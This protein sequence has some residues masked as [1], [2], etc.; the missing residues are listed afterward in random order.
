V[1]A[2]CYRPLDSINMKKIRIG[3]MGCASIAK[4]SVIPAIIKLDQYFEL[5]AIASRT[6]D[7]ANKFAAEFD[8]EGIEGYDNLISRPDIDAIYVPLPTGLH[9]EWILKT[10]NAGKHIYAEKSIALNS[11]DANQMIDLARVHDLALM[12]GYMFQYHSQHKKVFEMIHDGSL[13]EIRHFSASFGFPPLKSENFR[14]NNEI[15]GGALMDCA[16]YVVRSAFFILQQELR[17]K[18]SSVFFDPKTGTS[19]YGS[20]FMKGNNGIGASLSF[21]FDNFYQC[22]YKIWGSKGILTAMRAFTPKAEEIVSLIFET[23]GNVDTITIPA[24][25]HF[26]NAFKKFYT[27]CVGDD[28]ELQYKAIMEQSIALDAIAYLSK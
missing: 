11:I 21:G 1:P 25:N 9:K 16:G 15:G 13:G 27:L 28:K 2:V 10:L 8:C 7:K 12:E 3:I 14:Y 6:Q 18:A 24:D 4:N 22:N 23:Q 17:V 5:I 26:V 20:A 19:L